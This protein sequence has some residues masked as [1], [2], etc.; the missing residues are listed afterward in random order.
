MVVY[1][2][3]EQAVSHAG[4]EYRFTTAF[5]VADDTC[6]MSPEIPVYNNQ[7]VF[8][9]QDAGPRIVCIYSFFCI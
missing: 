3:W 5:A 4:F 2:I 7:S 6:S 9:Q 1:C 8:R